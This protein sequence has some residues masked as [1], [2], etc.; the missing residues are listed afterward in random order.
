MIFKKPPTSIQI[1]TFLGRLYSK[2]KPKYI[3]CD[4]GS[5][6]WC[7]GFKTWCKRNASHRGQ[8]TLAARRVMCNAGSG[9]RW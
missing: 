7:D 3:I 8:A 1:R 4:K 6:F 2:T 5:Q 9:H